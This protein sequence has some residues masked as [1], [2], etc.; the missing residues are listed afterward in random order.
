MRRRRRLLP[1]MGRSRSARP[2][3][4][5][6]SLLGGPGERRASG[7]RCSRRGC[8]RGAPPG[9]VLPPPPWGWPPSAPKS[10]LGAAAGDLRTRGR[11]GPAGVD[12]ARDEVTATPVALLPAPRHGVHQRGRGPLRRPHATRHGAEQRRRGG[13]HGLAAAR[14][15]RQRRRGA[16]LR[17]GAREVR[18][19]RSGG[20]GRVGGGGG[21]ELRGCDPWRWLGKHGERLLWCWL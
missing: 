4:S 10:S 6:A 3:P 21:A 12:G 18:E 8:R 9:R 13:R 16:G 1:S 15:G 14:G 7:R 17:R 11:H 20:E 2:T 5:V 19:G